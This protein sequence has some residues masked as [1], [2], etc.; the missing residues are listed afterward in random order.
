MKNNIYLKDLESNFKFILV[1][2]LIVL[3]IGI[4]TGLAY[5]YLTTAM[6]PSGTVEQFN[7]PNNTY[8]F[9]YLDNAPLETTKYANDLLLTTHNHVITFS[10]ISLLISIIFYF[11]SSI[12]DKFKLFLIFEPFASIILTFSSLWL[13]RYVD[14]IFVYIMIGSAILMYICWYL[15]IF[16]S[17]YELIKKNN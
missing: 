5:V 6:T 13:M 1:L 8:E 17:I 16:V 10:I 3:S 2:F 4:F 14:D 12:T 15:M 11:N 7:G 9:D